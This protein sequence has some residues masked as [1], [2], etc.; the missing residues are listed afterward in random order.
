M[1]FD[2]LVLTQE[3]DAQV[4]LAGFESQLDQV[5]PSFRELNDLDPG[6]TV[7]AQVVLAAQMD[8]QPPVPSYQAIPADDRQID[9]TGLLSEILSALDIGI[10]ADITQA[11]I[12]VVVIGF[13]PGEGKRE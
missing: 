1:H 7:H 8:L 11:G 13:L 3:C 6:M 12:A 2:F 5:P 4:Y 9:G 10:P